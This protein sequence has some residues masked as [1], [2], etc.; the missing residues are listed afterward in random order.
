MDA[1]NIRTNLEYEIINPNTN[2]VFLPPKGRHWRFTKEK[3]DEAFKTN[4]IIFGK[5]GKTKPQ[6]KR[7]LFEA[8][9]KGTNPFTIWSE[10]GTATDATKE[11]MQIFDGEKLFETPK[12]SSFIYRILELST[13]KNSI[14]LDSF[15]GSGTTAHAVLNLNK[16]DNGNRKFVL[17]E[18]M[19]Y[20]S[21]I[22][23][24]RVKRVIKGYGDDKK[25][26]E[27]TGGSFDYYELG[28]PLFL[29]EDILNES[30]GI[31]NILK[32]I[33]YSETRTPFTTIPDLAEVNYRIGSKDQ[34]DYYFYYLIDGQTTVDYDFM[35]KIKH[36]AS[37]YI[38]Y[39]DNCLL[40][41]DFMLKHH[42][43]F[44]KIPRDIT[45]F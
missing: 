45:R 37:Q 17:I 19:D 31:E 9:E 11:L 6:Y 5:T 13:D 43:I 29:E 22:T 40:E 18:M 12:P 3:Y 27:G 10:L 30:V 33:W 41:K 2:E 16:Q 15:S 34:T 24:E 32:Y 4:R 25:A 44:K 28:E 1:P 8:E 7:Y 35:A 14:I 26:I 42:I 39:A 20:A 23:A 21:N 36:K 38:I